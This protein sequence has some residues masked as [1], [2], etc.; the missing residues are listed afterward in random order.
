M[1]G[2]SFAASALFFLCMHMR[3][4]LGI[5]SLLLFLLSF[6]SASESYGLR[7]LQEKGGYLTQEEHWFHQTLD[8]FSPTVD[9]IPLFL[10]LL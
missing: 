6:P 1:H 3:T 4:L 8:H 5:I 10:S 2:H 9:L 7:R